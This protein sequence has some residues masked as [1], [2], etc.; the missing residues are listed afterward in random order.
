M[1]ILQLIPSLV[2]GG[3]EQAV[4]AINAALVQAGHD[5]LVVSSGGPRVAE[6]VAA[7]GRHIVM[8]LA[9]KNPAALLANAYRL[10]D[11]ITAQ[12][13]DIVHARSRAPAWSG[14]G[15]ARMTQRHFVTTFHAAYAFKGAAKKY[16]NGVM[17]R[18][19]RVIAISD[20]I[21]AHIR[22]NYP[23]ASGRVVTIPRGIDMA[24]FDA[25]AVTPERVASLR[26]QWGVPVR[27]RLILMP[28]RIS[29]IKGHTIL[30]EA[31]SQLRTAQPD[32]QFHAVII[33]A[34]QGRDDYV[35]ELQAA[36]AVAA[37]TAQVTL[38]GQCLDMP[39]AYAAADLVV[40]PSLVAEGFGRVPVEAQA[41]GVPVIASALG[42]FQETIIPDMTGWLV[43]PGDAAALAQKIAQALALDPAMRVAWAVTARRHVRD[44]YDQQKMIAATLDVYQKI[45]AA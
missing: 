6:I 37:L 24:A 27:S 26:A 38:A 8:P 21:A 12:G 31:L 36:L 29:R 44:R 14:W 35:R 28:A 17:A 15:A 34:A 19:E 32:L 39:A 5:S 42:G 45:L 43:P 3:A 10:A 16:Y 13:V 22:A 20:F 25:Q 40:A 1:N 7:G 30:I 23:Q 18:G 4:V 33:G 9:T 11:L 41:L 2:S